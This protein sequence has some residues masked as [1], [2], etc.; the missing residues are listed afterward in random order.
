MKVFVAAMLA[1]VLLS[2]IGILCLVAGAHGSNLLTYVGAL[3]LLP[4]VGLSRF[5]VPIGI[6]GL[7]RLGAV[8][9]ISFPVVQLAGYYALLLLL[10]RLR[11]HKKETQ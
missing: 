4:A 5:G 8:S 1:T 3:L 9:A 7:H 10:M 6:P 11:R 2:T